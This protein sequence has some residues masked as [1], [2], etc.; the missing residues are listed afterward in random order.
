MARRKS[1]HLDAKC[2]HLLIVFIFVFFLPHSSTVSGTQTG[3]GNT[4][5]L[6]LRHLPD[7]R[8]MA[9]FE[10][11]TSWSIHPLTFAQSTNGEQWLFDSKQ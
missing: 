9:H 1:S 7:G 3:Q 4:E 10:F 11:T 8:V 2:L 5:E 6:V